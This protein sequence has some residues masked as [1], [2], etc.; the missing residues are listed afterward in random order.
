[1]MNA[2]SSR[3]MT[4]TRGTALLLGAFLGLAVA[5]GPVIGPAMADKVGVAAAVNP[6]AYSSLSGTPNEQLKIGKSIFYNEHINTTNS[7]LVQVLL[8]DGSTFTVGPNSNLTIDKFVYDPRKKTGQI[9]AT[10]SKGTMRFIGGKLSKNDGGVTV[11]TPSGALAIR[12]GMFQGSTSRGVYSFLFGDS[13]TFRGNNGQTQTVYETGYSL[14]LSR[15]SANVRPTTP[16]DTNAFMQALTNSG[17]N[18]GSGTTGPSGPANPD[19]VQQANIENAADQQVS[20]ANFVMIQTSIQEQLA[21]LNN[22]RDNTTTTPPSQGG[23]EP[24]PVIKNG[25]EFTG[26]S[27]GFLQTGPNGTGTPEFLQNGIVTVELDPDGNTVTANINTD[28]VRITD[29]P[30]FDPVAWLRDLGLIPNG[31]GPEVTLNRQTTTLTNYNFG[32]GGSTANSDYVDDNIFLAIEK[33]GSTHVV[34]QVSTSGEINVGEFEYKSLAF[35]RVRVPFLGWIWVPYQETKT[36]DPFQISLPLSNQTQDFEDATH[37]GNFA[38]IATGPDGAPTTLCTD[39]DFMKFGFWS[40]DATFGDNLEKM[41]GWWVAG[42]LTDIADLNSIALNEA[43]F[44]GSA[45]GTAAQQQQNGVWSTKIATGQANMT[46]NFVNRNGSLNIN[47]F[48]GNKNFSYNN[49]KQLQVQNAYINR[50][51]GNIT[52]GATSGNTTG[53]FVNGPKGPAT[54]AIGSWNAAGGT[55]RANGIFGVTR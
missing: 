54:G 2:Q 1:M 20:D 14:D 43:T 29:G 25:F 37:V 33:D 11:K 17:T 8:V 27:S 24:E 42:D 46:W 5:F 39:C 38:S 35:K 18:F 50:F 34:R 36:S 19:G 51:G 31:V 30:E 7:G 41:G 16:E 13:L 10:F 44:S 12:G 26:F 22:L 15:G 28:H 4:G 55:Y 45:I 40:S 6:D 9:V 48:D 23:T 53:A 47:N 32:F 49:L 3:G 21:R 52:S